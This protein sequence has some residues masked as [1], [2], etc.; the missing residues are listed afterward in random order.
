MVG[1]ESLERLIQELSKMPTI[2]RRT[3]QRLALYLVKAPKEEVEAL[4]D[5]IV[6]MKQRIRFCSECGA[7]TEDEICS[8]CSDPKRDRSVI[9][10]VEEPGNVMRIEG[11]GEYKGLYHVLHGRLSPLDG[12]GPED[13]SLD[14]LKQRIEE[15]GVSEVIIA[16]NPNVEGEATS[17]YIAQALK[18]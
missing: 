9:C 12:I 14:R 1:S 3:A 15:L 17:N 7:L 4:V 18:P 13:L 5:A 2:G 11:T 10:V 8:I 6:K 16:T